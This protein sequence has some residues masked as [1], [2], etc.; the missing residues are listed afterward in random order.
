MFHTFF[1]LLSTPIINC[2]E[3]D[4]KSQSR[5]DSDSVLFP[6]WKTASPIPYVTPPESI[7]P[8]LG[9]LP[10]SKTYVIKCL[11]SM[12]QGRQT[13]S[14]IWGIHA[15][16]RSY[17]ALSLSP[18]LLCSSFF[19]KANL[20]PSIV[21]TNHTSICTRAPASLSA[22]RQYPTRLPVPVLVGY[23]DPR[24]PNAV[25]LALHGVC[26]TELRDVRK[27]AGF[28]RQSPLV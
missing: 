7:R 2:K 3:L 21:S 26:A 20:Y 18:R 28:G 24:L 10:F 15:D 12:F 9:H 1:P 14:T 6:D 8:N 5:I 25:L 19:P 13:Q 11:F 22:V 27:R 23:F 16:P 4:I 17:P